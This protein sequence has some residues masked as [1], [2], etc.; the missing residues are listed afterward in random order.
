M[1][2]AHGLCNCVVRS[3]SCAAQSFTYCSAAGLAAGNPQQ[4]IKSKKYGNSKKALVVLTYK[5]YNMLDIGVLCR[6]RVHIC[7]A[8][9]V[10]CA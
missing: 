3:A 7:D 1:L 6:E 8:E 2:R 5:Y 9:N 10:K 4:A